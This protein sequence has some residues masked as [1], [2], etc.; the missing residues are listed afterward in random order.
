MMKSICVLFMVIGILVV[1][2]IFVFYGKEMVY[3]KNYNEIGFVCFI[4]D[5]Y[6]NFIVFLVYFGFLVIYFVSCIVVIIF[7]YL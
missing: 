5:L 3:L 2:F 4:F 7:V 6:R 1:S